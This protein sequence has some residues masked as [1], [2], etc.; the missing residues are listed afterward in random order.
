[1]NPIAMINQEFARMVVEKWSDEGVV[2]RQKQEAVKS[3]VGVAAA[4]PALVSW[5][6]T[7]IERRQGTPDP[8]LLPESTNH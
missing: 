1:M 6:R 4:I 8:A 2:C 7:R 5:V 3:R